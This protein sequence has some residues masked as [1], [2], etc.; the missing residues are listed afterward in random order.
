MRAALSLDANVTRRDSMC[1]NV[2]GRMYFVAWRHGAFS[3]ELLSS[4]ALKNSMRHF[5]E[6]SLLKLEWKYVVRD[7][8]S[9]R[10][11]YSKLLLRFCINLLLS[12]W[13]RCC[14]NIRECQ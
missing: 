2:L 5:Y 1:A 10:V 11:P 6:A 7:A 9:P 12:F 14:G 4:P 13:I 3:D 8:V